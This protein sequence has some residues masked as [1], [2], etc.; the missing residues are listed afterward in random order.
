MHISRTG[1]AQ[2]ARRILV[3]SSDVTDSERLLRFVTGAARVGLV[4]VDSQYRY[5]FANDAYGEIFGLTGESIVGRRVPDL[6]ASA[7]PQIQPRLDQAIA[8]DKVAYELTI[9]SPNAMDG[10]RVYSVRYEPHRDEAGAFSVLVVVIEIT[11]QRA[12]QEALRESENRLRL[13]QQVA[14]IGTFDRRIDSDASIW[15]PELERLYGLEPTDKPRTRDDLRALI[16]PDDR[17]RANEGVARAFETKLP[18]DAEWRVVWPDGSI[19]W[20]AARF[21]VIVDADGKPV[22]LTGVNIDVTDQRLTEAALHEHRLQIEGIVSAA[23]NGIVT[24]DDARRIVLINPAAEH[25]LRCTASEVLGHSADLFFPSSLWADENSD[26]STREGGGG[27]RSV[28]AVRMDGEHFP[29]EASVSHVEID[30]RRRT[31]VICR[32]VTEREREAVARS[33]LEAQL[34]AAQKMEAFGQLAGGI[35]HDFNNLLLIINGYGQLLLGQ[36]PAEKD[37]EMLREICLAG[38]R[39]A[40]L[41]RQLLAFSRQQVLEPKVVDLNTIVGDVDRMLR[42]LIGEDVELASLLRPGL[43]PVRVDPSQMEQVLLNLALNARDAMPQGGRLT[44]ETSE[45]DLD[46]RYTA[47]HPEVGTG[48]YVKLTVS[49]SGSGMTEEVKSRLFEPF[50][51]T[52][53]RDKGTGLGLAVVHGIVKQS[54][55]SISVYSEPGV[56]TTFAIYLPVAKAA[57][58]PVPAPEEVHMPTGDE[59]IL[60]VEDEEAVRHLATL[61]LEKA[62]YRLLTASSGDE[63]LRIAHENDTQIDLVVT[64]VV[65]PGSSGRQTVER[66]RQTRSGFKVLFMSGYTDDAVVR[67][68]VL[69][70]NVAYL[71]K[72]FT[73]TALARKVREVL[74]GA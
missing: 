64:D 60:L 3:P 41:T 25:M 32:D 17:E 56:G 58:S 51:T 65:M 45:V 5:L 53:G 30:G 40:A 27:F 55:G 22:R 2:F 24:V 8:G 50:F 69:Q 34:R 37:A 15:T 38:E 61:V 42:R 54:G 46:R 23:L 66:L 26:V 6:L 44:I 39:A 63:A 10:H 28:E 20:I 1:S 13:A 12:A 48:R 21:Q 18:T 47:T 43:Q 59:T 33:A 70:A 31:T 49:D 57:T 68:G 11:E 19:H 29:I 67:H 71:Q 73:P 16:H 14:R 9:P 62:G 74:D 72:P 36:M 35:A 52:K 4:V 7:W